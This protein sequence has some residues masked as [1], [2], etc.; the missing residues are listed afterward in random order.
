MKINYF[1]KF[2]RFFVIYELFFRISRFFSYFTRMFLILS[3]IREY[4]RIFLERLMDINID[5]TMIN[6]VILMNANDFEM[7]LK[8]SRICSRMEETFHNLF[9]P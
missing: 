2:S 1:S 4:F 6:Y 8:C 5:T 7:F 3:N 9:A